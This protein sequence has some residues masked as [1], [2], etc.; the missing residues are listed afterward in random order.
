MNKSISALFCLLGTVCFSTNANAYLN[1]EN[2]TST[3]DSESEFMESAFDVVFTKVDEAD[4]VFSTY[5]IV[6]GKWEKV[7]Y[8]YDLT[9]RDDI[10]PHDRVEHYASEGTIEGHFFDYDATQAKIVSNKGKLDRVSGDFVNNVNTT[11]FSNEISGSTPATVNLIEGDFINN[12]K[13]TDSS[14]KGGALVNEA[15]VG[16]ITGNFIGNKSSGSVETNGGAINNNNDQAVIENIYGNF[17]NNKVATSAGAP[18]QGGAIYNYYSSKIG[19]IR[20]DFIA[21]Q[22]L[23]S[24]MIA[25]GGAIHNLN[26][27]EIGVIEGDFIGNFAVG[28]D[29]WR[30]MGGAI[31]NDNSIIGRITGDFIGNYVSDFRALGGAIYNV[32]GTIGIATTEDKKE[33]LFENNKVIKVYNG[34]ETPS[35]N[36]IDFVKETAIVNFHTLQDTLINVRDP[37]RSIDEFENPTTG[38][39]INKTGLG[40]LYLWGDNSEYFGEF[41]VKEGALYAMYDQEPDLIN[42]PNGQRLNFD[43]SN[44][45]VVF[46]S[47]TSFRPLMTEAKSSFLGSSAV[48]KDN[49]YLVPY[50]LS[51]HEIGSYSYAHDYSEFTGWSN[52]LASVVV[53]NGTTD[54]EIKRD[55]EGYKNL[56]ALADTYRMRTDLSLSEREMF[57]NIY[58]TGEISKDAEEKFAV[59]AG[60]DNIVYN[61]VHKSGIRQFGRQISS[62]VQNKNCPSCGMSNGFSDEHL[63]LNI[64]QN[65]ID[66]DSGK[67]TIGYKYS[68]TS[69]ALGYDYD[70][71]PNALNLG[72]AVSYAFGDVEGKGQSIQNKAEVDEYLV[73]LYGKYKPQRVYITGSLGGGIITNKTDVV[74]STINSTGQYNTKTLFAN[75]EFGYDIGNECGVVEPFVGVEYAYLYNDAYTE[76]GIGARK[77][78]SAYWNSVEIPVGLRVSR[79]MVF[80]TYIIT[81]AMELA[82]SRNVGDTASEV[83]ASFVGNPNSPWT[84]RG[85]A[86]KRDSVRG[87]FNFKI[88]NI[89]TPIA[90][91]FGYARDANSSYHDDQVY[92]TIRYNF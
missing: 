65:W 15:K 72:L 1:L 66:R 3:L 56:T 28:L 43:L 18:A 19:T 5:E 16:T 87:S 69:I 8:K 75:A 36:S 27:A 21:N 14:V 9:P 86:T 10:V 51:S 71:I 91:N 11:P 79:N 2:Y 45:K 4:A 29:G 90:F 53:E 6:D 59:I 34:V 84:F 22:A 60:R 20:G 80:D 25:R 54:I 38:G 44:A 26:H 33:I 35:L 23:A 74:S 83:R 63:W 76:K 68:P 48:L 92:L 89:L 37:M 32:E 64:G 67:T 12:V 46:E 57:D 39:V 30:S 81:P 42:D 62:R 85:D 73:S 7:F 31:Y 61:E 47:G 13:T 49:V 78:K 17:I 55:L 41:N 88:N 40:S 24:K 77:F 70:F 50:N 52:D 58:Y 82:Y